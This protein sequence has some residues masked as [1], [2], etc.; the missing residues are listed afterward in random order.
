MSPSLLET[1]S[2]PHAIRRESLLKRFLRFLVPDRRRSIRHVL[3][4][5]VSYLGIVGASKPYMV[6]DI[7][8]TGFYMLTH[9]HWIPGTYLPI[10]L[11]R[12]DLFSSRRGNFITVQACV[13]R[14][15]TD[16]VGFAF[17]LAD[18][19]SEF[20]DGLVGARWVT[21]RMMA[22]FLVG[23]QQS[24]PVAPEIPD[25]LSPAS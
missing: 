5:L 10:S 8:C 15:G 19:D 24:D 2:A 9:E 1:P 13:V 6:G 22:D 7:S 16:G 4:P 21:R 20:T 23:L 18:S 25:V 3:P 11:E 17:L 12:T 14:N